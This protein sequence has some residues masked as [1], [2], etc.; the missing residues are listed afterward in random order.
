MR[1]GR[2]RREHLLGLPDRGLR[3]GGQQLGGVDVAAVNGPDAR[4]G[5]PD[6]PAAGRQGPLAAP[7]GP[8]EVGDDARHHRLEV[9]AATGAPVVE[10]GQGSWA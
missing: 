5:R 9:H 1:Q 8:V 4:R 2:E 10:V 3:L 7:V 6:R